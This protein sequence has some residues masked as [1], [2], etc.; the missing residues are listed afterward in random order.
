MLK[1]ILLKGII[2]VALIESVLILYLLN[3]LTIP[4]VIANLAL[5]PVIIT[6]YCILSI[7]R[8]KS[9]HFTQ[10]MR[11]FIQGFKIININKEE[12]TMAAEVRGKFITLAGHLMSLF[13]EGLK[14]ADDELYRKTGKHYNELDPE[15]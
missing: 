6:F 11:T 5:A 15:G 14:S 12:H 10:D 4:I 7:R 13:K 2:A 8:Y 1:L 3:L 9:I